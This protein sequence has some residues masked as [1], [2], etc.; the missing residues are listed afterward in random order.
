MYTVQY[1][2]SACPDFSGLTFTIF[3][4]VLEIY[5]FLES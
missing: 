2:H 3:V 1:M 4:V 5:T